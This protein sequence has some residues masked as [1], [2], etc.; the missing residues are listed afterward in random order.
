MISTMKVKSFFTRLSAVLLA[1]GVWQAAV[2]YIDLP[3]FLPSPIEVLKRMSSIWKDE[4]FLHTLIFTFGRVIKGFLYGFGLGT[5]LAIIAGRWSMIETLLWPY[6]VTVK[7]VPVASFVILALLWISSAEL[8]VFISFLMVLPIIYTNVLQGYKAV[9]SKMKQMAKVFRLPFYKQLIYIYLP[10]IK[11]F[12]ISAC[13]V[14]FGLAWK[15]GVAAELIGQPDG[16]VGEALY[17][18]K[19]YLQTVDLF[20]WTLILIL[21]SISF[22]K[23]F[24]LLLKSIF[25]GVERL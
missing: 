11:P 19:L 23:L 3:I 21:I 14:A 6:M 7:S 1:L 4:G 13:S 24:L 12:M 8:S 22:E 10:T 25:K 5:A 16:S 2:C 15:S 9:D 17:Y 18:S 20:T